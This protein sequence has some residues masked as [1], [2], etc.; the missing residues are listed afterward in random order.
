MNNQTIPVFVVGSGRS[1]TRM[2]YRLLSGIPH[3]ETYH[4]FECTHIQP[5]AAKYYMKIV[6][7][8]E[9]KKEINKLHGAAIHYS[10]VKYWVDSS[11]KLSWLIEPLSELFPEAKFVHLIRD[12]RKV[13]SSFYHKL[14]PEIYD[15]ESVKIMMEWIKNKTKNPEPPPEKKYWW[16]I[17]QKGQPF[18]KEFSEL[19]QFQKIC[20]HWKEI[21]REVNQSL[22][23]VPKKQKLI[24]KLEDLS[25]KKTV[26]KQF[27]SFFDISYDEHFFE[28]VKKPQNVFFPMDL[29]MTKDEEKEFN[30]ICGNTMIKLGYKNKSEYEVKY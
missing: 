10:K 23:L 12:G 22:K 24:I 2:I 4:E 3:I 1:G 28:Y 25:S 19:S 21:I 7:K 8:E 16:N 5:I 17:P 6:T 29:K 18:Y 11:N 13:V 30:R 15:D 26:L 20:Y 9:A 14:A 27:L